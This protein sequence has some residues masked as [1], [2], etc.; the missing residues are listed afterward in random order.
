MKNND[1]GAE[2]VEQARYEQ[3]TSYS[4]EHLRLADKALGRI[5]GE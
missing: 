2:T 3:L 5:K 4:L 1:F